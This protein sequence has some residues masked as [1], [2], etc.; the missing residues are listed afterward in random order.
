MRG[1]QRDILTDRNHSLTADESGELSALSSAI[2]SAILR[3][4]LRRL[5]LRLVFVL[6][7]A[8]CNLCQGLGPGGLLD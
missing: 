2:S 7:L 5:K 8:E 4:A 1:F 6:Q 3:D